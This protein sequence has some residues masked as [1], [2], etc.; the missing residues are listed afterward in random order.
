MLDNTWRH[1]GAMML[2]AA[3]ALP[4]A[5]MAQQKGTAGESPAQKSAQE[6][7]QTAHPVPKGGD[8]KLLDEAARNGQDAPV[9]PHPMREGQKPKEPLVRPAP[10][11]GSTAVPGWNNPPAWGSISESRQY[12]SIP[13]VDRSQL[14]QGDGRRWREFRNGP[15]TNYGGWLFG[16][17]FLA[18]MVFYLVMGPVKLKHPPTGRLIERFN[19]VE[20]TAHWTTAISFVLLALTGV[21]MLWG[22]HIIL[23]W[24][25]YSGFSTLTVFG[26]NL[27]NFVG[28]LFIFSILVTFLIF[29]RDNLFRRIDWTWIAH[30]GGMYSAKE[31]PS[32]RFNG[33]EKVWFWGGLTLLGLVMAVTGLIL[34]FPNWDQSRQLMQLANVVHDIA[35]VLFIAA[36]FGH[37]YIGTIGMQGAYRAM[38]EG[39]VD[40][41]WAREHHSIWYDEVRAG[42]RPEKILG[43]TAVPAAGDD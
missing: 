23:P 15:L 33:L 5:A 43:G 16:I 27:H 1:L 13:G 8:L 4:L 26:K 24:L 22:K 35:A 17:V 20:R 31:I 38:R 32:G 29:V 36:S 6:P 40:E 42:K 28:P 25:G 9:T 41:E 12:A 34:D 18:I 30:F 21:I 19:A 11:Q 2:G 10:V 3:L 14:I 7:V 37:V 39:Y